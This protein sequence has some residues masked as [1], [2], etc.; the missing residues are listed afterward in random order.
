MAAGALVAIMAV[1]M[2]PLWPLVMRQGVWYLSVGMMGLLGLFFAMAIFR[3]ILFAITVFVVPPG[4]WLYPNLFEDVGFFDSFRPVWGWQEVNGTTL[5]ILRRIADSVSRI[6]RPRGKQRRLQR[7]T[8]STPRTN[9]N[10]QHH[11]QELV[12]ME[13]PLQQPLDQMALQPQQW[14]QV[15]D[16]KHHRWK[17]RMMNDR[18]CGRNTKHLPFTC[19]QYSITGIGASD[20]RL[21]RRAFLKYWHHHDLMRNMEAHVLFI[22]WISRVLTHRFKGCHHSSV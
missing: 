22:S 19:T 14:S 6:K 2:F 20:H 13:H 10:Q 7:P 17:K 21:S 4:L 9:H 8:S 16:T 15:D 1:V 11:R 5:C 12:A 3:L 18:S